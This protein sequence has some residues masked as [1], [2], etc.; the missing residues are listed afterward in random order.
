M[1]TNVTCRLPTG[2]PRDCWTRS[3]SSAATVPASTATWTATAPSSRSLSPPTKL[4]WSSARKER[5]SNSCR[6]EMWP[7]SLSKSPHRPQRHYQQCGRPAKLTAPQLTPGFTGFF[8][9]SWFIQCDLYIVFY[10]PSWILFFFFCK[11]RFFTPCTPQQLIVWKIRYISTPVN[12]WVYPT[13]LISS[14]WQDTS[15]IRC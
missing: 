7:H 11:F 2:R 8:R 5:P 9:L 12:D 13:Y 10:S 6:S 3:W 15:A 4:A 1:L 14:I